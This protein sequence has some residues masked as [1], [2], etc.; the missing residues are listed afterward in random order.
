NESKRKH[1]IPK[2]K[3]DDTLQ[4]LTRSNFVLQQAYITDGVPG[5]DFAF[6]DAILD[7]SLMFNIIPKRFQDRDVDDDLLFDIARGNKSH[8]AS[9]IVKWFHT[10]YHYLVP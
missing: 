10:N 3:L 5:G 1:K 2:A 4:H 7:T 8:V 9:A 6:D